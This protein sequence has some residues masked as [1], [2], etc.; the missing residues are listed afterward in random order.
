MSSYLSSPAEN[1]VAVTPNDSTDIALGSR[2]ILCG[3]AGTAK[4]T[5]KAGQSV[6]IPLQQGYNPIAVTRVWFTGTTATDIWALY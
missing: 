5:T 3:T 2:A 6:T 1:I 4:V